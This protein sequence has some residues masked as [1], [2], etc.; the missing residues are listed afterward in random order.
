MLFMV[1]E[2][3]KDGHVR[4]VGHRFQRRGRM[5]PDWVIYHASGVD[6]AATKCFQIMEAPSRELLNP[7]VKQWRDLG[8]I[9]IV[10]IVTSSEFWSKVPLEQADG[11]E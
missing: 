5:L 6:L 10:P 4:A 11:A 1:I 8:E 3:F 7:W 9:E 2:Q